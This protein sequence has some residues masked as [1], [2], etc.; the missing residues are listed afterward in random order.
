MLKESDIIATLRAAFSPEGAVG[1]GDDCAVLPLNERESY[2]IS[3]DMLVEHRH[4]RLTTTNVADL[5]HKSL[6]V[7]LSDVAAMGAEPLFVM[8]GIALPPQLAKKWVDEFLAAFTDVCKNASVQLIGGDTTASERDLF[9]SVTI[10]GKA[11]NSC[12]RFRS[13]A[14]NGDIICVA[15]ALGEA[16][17][18]L[19][20]LEKQI[21]SLDA[22]KAK[23]QRPTA[24]NAEGLWFGAQSSVTALMDVSDGLYLDLKKMAL[25]SGVGAVLDVEMLRP[26]VELQNAVTKLGLDPLECM[27]VGG[28]DYVLLASVRADQFE[29]ITKEFVAKFGYPL[30]KLGS[31]V[32]GTG[33]ELR[34]GGMPIPF[35]HKPFSHFGEL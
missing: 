10:I 34:R 4:F 35:T 22:I 31:V 26:S 12:L 24:R 5:A 17:A 20:A 15:G 21:D 2:V 13:G 25:A 30:R 18:G 23:S 16:H 3:K 19:I 9:I 6:H 33:V 7:N 14:K 27:L 29:I 1:I 28:E 11:E 8:L 32:A